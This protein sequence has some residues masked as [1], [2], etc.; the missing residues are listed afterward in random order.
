MITQMSFMTLDELQAVR[1]TMETW[2]SL[3]VEG[4]QEMARRVH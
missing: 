4:L 1:D 3:C 2:S